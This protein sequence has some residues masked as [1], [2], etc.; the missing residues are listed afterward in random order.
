MTLYSVFARLIPL[1]RERL[2][3]IIKLTEHIAVDKR[4]YN[5]RMNEILSRV[6][7]VFYL[8]HND[9]VKVVAVNEHEFLRIFEE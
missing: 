8:S 6:V 2:V 4:T 3:R 7:S 9:S 1:I 5:D